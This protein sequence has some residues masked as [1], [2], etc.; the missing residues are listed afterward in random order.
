MDGVL[1]FLQNYFNINVLILFLIS[2]FF[3]LYIDCKEYKRDSL[4][5]EYKFAK[6]T[7]IVFIIVGFTIYEFAKFIRV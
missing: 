6:Y 1:K 7:A 3:L 5:R 2:S 4:H